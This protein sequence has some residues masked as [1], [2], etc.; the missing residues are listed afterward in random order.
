MRSQWIISAR[1]D[2]GWLLLPALSG[3]FFLYLNALGI[4]SFLLW[5]FWNVSVNG[6]H[7]FA[8]IS[9]TYLDAE[10]WRQR[11]AL[12]IGSLGFL[13]LGPAVIALCLVLETRLPFIVFW[14]FQAVWAYYHVVRQHFGFMALYQKRNGEAVGRENLADFWLFNLVMLAPAVAWLV[15]YPDLRSALGW[16]V[17][18]SAPVRQ[19][20]GLVWVAVGIAVAAFVVKEAWAYHRTRQV[21]LPKLLLLASYVPLHLV[22]FLHP[23]V[24]TGFD[25]LLINA[26]V[27]FPHS[28]QYVAFVWFY[29]RKRYGSEAAGRGFG[30]ARLVSRSVATYLGCA[31][32]FGLAFY[33][34]EWF[35]E[36]RRVPFAPGFYRGA[37][38]PIGQG[39]ELSHLVAV[40]W[41][42]VVFNHQYLDQKIWHIR[43]DARLN[44]DLGLT[45]GALAPELRAS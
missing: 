13:L 26:V 44:R 45:G 4:S 16:S 7:F 17:Q 33:Y 32:V 39:F 24:A 18:P 2:A 20:F 38:I 6:P 19:L 8:T 28:V 40:T 34:L 15:Q 43:S 1:G 11:K 5:W 23:A 22:L 21:N 3:Y 14:L 10:E 36:A 35:L 9:R 30:P 37:Q 25:L 41:L 27:T 42:G 31:I 29:N 12:L